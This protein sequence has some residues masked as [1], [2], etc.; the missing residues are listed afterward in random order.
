MKI[1]SASVND[2]ARNRPKL[3]KWVLASPSRR[4]YAVIAAPTVVPSCFDS[5]VPASICPEVHRMSAR[6]S[7]LSPM[8]RAGTVLLLL[9]GTTAAAQQQCYLVRDG[10]PECTIPKKLG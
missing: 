6:P 4:S 1:G 9:A 10:R 7:M 5:L 3:R 8:A 2:R